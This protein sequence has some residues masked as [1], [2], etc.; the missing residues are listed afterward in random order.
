MEV[1]VTGGTGQVGSTVIEMLAKRGDDVLAIGRRL[2]ETIRSSLR[3]AIAGAAPAGAAVDE[4][5]FA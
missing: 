3:S 2:R 4:Q 1:F 5:T